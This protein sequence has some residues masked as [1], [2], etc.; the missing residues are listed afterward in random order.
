[1]VNEK[2]ISPEIMGI[3]AAGGIPIVGISGLSM[4]LSVPMEFPLNIS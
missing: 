4:L 3:L 2:N 1:M